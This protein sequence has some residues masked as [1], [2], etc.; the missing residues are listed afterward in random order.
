MDGPS[1]E[2]FFWVGE[3]FGGIS[4]GSWLD[5]LLDLFWELWRLLRSFGK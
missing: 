3:F 2:V 1:E 4:F 5:W